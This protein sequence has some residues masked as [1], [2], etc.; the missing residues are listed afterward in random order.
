M[1]CG[2]R[3]L[4]KRIR[5]GIVSA[6][7]A[8][9]LMPLCA[10]LAFSQKSDERARKI[11]GANACAECHKDEATVWKGTHHFSTFREMPRSK[12][13]REIASKLKIRRIKAD[14]LCLGCHFT[15]EAVKGRIK[16]TSGIS[17][18]SCHGAGAGWQKIHS[19]FSGKGNKESESKPEA[20]ARWKKSEGHGM[21]RPASL[22]KL[23]K[24]CY[25]C[26]VVPNERLVNVGEH[27]AGSPFELVSWSQG[28]VRH[29]VWYSKGQSNAKSTQKRK[30]MMYVTGISVEVETALRA[31]GVATKKKS[32]A[33]RMAH[34]ADL[35]RKKMAAIATAL[36]KVPEIT[37]IVSLSHSAGLK[38]NNK[39]KLYKAADQIASV[40]QQFLTKYDGS[41]FA[42][43]DN[44]LP[45]SSDY[46]GK[47]AK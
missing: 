9:M 34:R 47:P 39:E 17:C 14:S 18:E 22:Y 4:L 26:H 28:E 41:T 21:I 44:L 7:L 32:Y 30:R 42:G 40:V 16:A 11:V 10:T 20:S 13:A 2:F 31:I 25:G 45:P 8:A 38:L 24:N 19:E 12:Q 43:I 29:N 5:T 1:T 15:Q 23:A 33:I 35:A 6:V 27:A 3:Q 46:R 37:R 36:P